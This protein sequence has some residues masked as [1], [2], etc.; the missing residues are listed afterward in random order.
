VQLLVLIQSVNHNMYFNF[1][2][3]WD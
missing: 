3:H 2:W 1:W